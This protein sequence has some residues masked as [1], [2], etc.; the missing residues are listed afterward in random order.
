MDD[1]PA[2]A[3]VSDEGATDAGLVHFVAIKSDDAF[4]V[5]DSHGDIKGG[6]D[7]LFCAD[8][9]ILSRFGFTVCERRP[10]LLSSGLSHDS[11]VFRFHGANLDLPPVGGRATPR[12]VIHIERQRVLF[13]NHMFERVRC[14]N[15]GLDEVMLP[16]AFEYGADFRDMF[17]V[18]GQKRGRRGQT[19]PTRITGRHVV[20][21]YDGLDGVRRTSALAFSEP[22]WR[23]TTQRAD[24][25]FSL[26]PGERVDL[27]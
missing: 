19:L 14:A 21:A 12:G 3:L 13:E 25:M 27:F 26:R 18:R 16:L 11:V 5:C 23:M 7:G 20:F 8:T 10:S 15:Y 22:P 9:R 6:A 24:F 1:L 4:L 2:P 17:E